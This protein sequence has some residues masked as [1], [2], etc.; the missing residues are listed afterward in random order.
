[1]ALPLGI[2]A[3]VDSIP[4]GPFKVRPSFDLGWRRGFGLSRPRQSVTVNNTGQAYVFYGTPLAEDALTV[5]LGADIL[6]APSLRLHLGYDGFL[7]SH[8]RDNAV[9][10]RLA[11]RF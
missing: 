7:S 6:I 2:R 1:M 4:A 8:S 10:G 9:T 5:N 3:L 11:W